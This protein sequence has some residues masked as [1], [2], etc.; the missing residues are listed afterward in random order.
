[1]RIW[2]NLGGRAKLASFWQASWWPIWRRW[3]PCW[4]VRNP[5]ESSESSRS[6]LVSRSLVTRAGYVSRSFCRAYK[7]ARWYGDQSGLNQR[8][9]GIALTSD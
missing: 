7:D 1:M 3:R 2:R 4:R 9:V 6:P 8:V 5:L